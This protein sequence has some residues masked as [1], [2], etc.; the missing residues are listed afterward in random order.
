VRRGL[1]RALLVAIAAAWGCNALLGNEDGA[2]T[3]DASDGSVSPDGSVD[4]DGSRTDGAVLGD[5]GADGDAAVTCT[6][7]VMIDPANCGACGHDCLGGGCT[8]GLCEAV[9]MVGDA[10]VLLGFA[11]NEDNAY[12]TSTLRLMRLPLD[13]KSAPIEFDDAP[14]AT[15]ASKLVVSATDVVWTLSPAYKQLQTCPAAGCPDTGPFALSEFAS[16]LPAAAM[17]DG[18]LYWSDDGTQLRVTPMDGGA[19]EVFADSGVTSIAI[20]PPYVYYGRAKDGGSVEQLPL[21]GGAQTTVVQPGVPTGVR[22]IGVAGNVLVWTT[23][24]GIFRSATDGG[25]EA[26]VT[27]EAATVD[28]IAI[29]GNWVYWKENTRAFKR[30]LLASCKP[31]LVTP[32]QLV[33]FAVTKRFIVWGDKQGNIARL[34]R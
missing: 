24:A 7:N 4:N 2:F 34:T 19:T 13:G 22:A 8:N 21:T 18:L 25:Q 10:G 16:P 32:N 1:K 28:H 14:D 17:K 23:N 12:W 5:G 30:C 33:D 31:E 3:D 29:A 11:A 20:E 27:T 15:T 9:T 26:L 6:A